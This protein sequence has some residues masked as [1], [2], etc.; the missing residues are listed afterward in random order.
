MAAVWKHAT[1]IEYRTS[2]E[3]FGLGRYTL[4]IVCHAIAT[5]LLTQYV[6]IPQDDKLKEVDAYLEFPQAAGINDNSHIP[7]IH[8]DES[9]SDYYNYLA[10]YG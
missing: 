3:L 2:S 7:I 5:R 8:P 1:N 6:S 10:N 4:M 9:A